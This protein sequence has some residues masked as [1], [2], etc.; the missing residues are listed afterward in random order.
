MFG[1]KKSPIVDLVLNILIY[2]KYKTT[3]LMP[4]FT[5]ITRIVTKTLRKQYENIN[6]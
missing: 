6:I 3:T 1:T 5:K 2:Y 4:T